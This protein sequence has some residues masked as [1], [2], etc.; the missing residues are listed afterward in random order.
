MIKQRELMQRFLWSAMLLV[1]FQIG[2]HIDLPMFLSQEA[3]LDSANS[4]LKFLSTATGGNFST[5]TLFSLGMG[6]YMTA[7]IIWTTISMIDEE[8]VNNFS[9][10]QIGYIQR[11][12][13]LIFTVIQSIAL[14]LRFKTSI[15]TVAFFTSETSALLAGVLLL[16]TG[17]M[18]ISWL[19]D[20]NIMKGIGGQSLF[21]LPGLMANI[22]SMLISGQSG[23]ISFT[24]QF[25]I[26]L[27]LITL[28]FIYLTMY[29]YHSEYRIVIERTG[30][31]T[32]SKHSY[33]P[34]RLL[35]AGAMPFMFAVTVFSMPQLLLLNA[36]WNDTWFSNFITT[37]FSFNS[38][39]GIIMYGVVL[40]LLGWGFSFINIRPNDIAK[41][42]KE[43]GDYIL[44]VPPG[45]QTERY[46][47][48]KLTRISFVG[49]AY[50]VFISLIPMFIGLRSP[51]I[52]NLAF[53][54]GSLFMLIIILDTL[55][56]EIRFVYSKKEYRLF[57]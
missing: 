31:D 49:N 2:R 30:I 27:I 28:L 21:I 54:F 14:V 45:D 22:P 44:N 9:M 47:R 15:V 26:I 50:L 46:I 12:L 42:L 37:Y 24:N 39:Q 56:Q 8:R 48:E 17:G 20:I 55:V 11:G 23:P 7:L 53:Y 36:K 25:I 5:I 19:A 34:I 40:Y 33:I 51:F 52:S 35:P 18:F 29:L 32:I 43:S 1:V 4:V 3:K 10:K 6:P 38:I 16:T 41:N 57:E 13:T